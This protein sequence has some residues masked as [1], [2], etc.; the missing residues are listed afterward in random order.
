L[1]WRYESKLKEL[2]STAGSIT[3]VAGEIRAFKREAMYWPPATTL[4]EDLVQALIA[5]MNG[6][7]VVYAPHAM[8][9]EHASATIDQEATRRARLMAGASQGLMW[10]LPRMAVRQPRL[11]WQVLS[12][13]GLRPLVPAALLAYGASSLS[14][15][16]TNRS[17]RAMVAAEAAFYVCALLGRRDEARGRYR[18]WTYFPYYFCRMNAAAMSG[19]VGLARRRQGAAWTRVARG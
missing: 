4:T 7:R 9:V 10:L 1:Y 19:L 18:R 2:E 14:L 17:A 15:A 3:A 13:K 6:W 16:R 5:A 11:A 8:S 12:H